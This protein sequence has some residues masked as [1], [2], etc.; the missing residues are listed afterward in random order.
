MATQW[1]LWSDPL[2][3]ISLITGFAMLSVIQT[4]SFAYDTRMAKKGSLPFWYGS[5]RRWTFVYLFV[6]T[7]IIF[8]SLFSKV[9]FI[10]KST[11]NNR[12]ETLKSLQKLSDVEFL[13]K[14][15]ELKLQYDLQDMEILSSRM[16]SHS[17]YANESEGD[18]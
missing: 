7:T 9:E 10:Q 14:V 5:F 15:H 13:E 1:L 17:Q 18:N 8:T 12:I 3:S 6:L 16:S 4:S 11:S 2:T